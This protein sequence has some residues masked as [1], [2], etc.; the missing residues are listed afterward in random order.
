MKP[1]A[2]CGDW[3]LVLSKMAD[4]GLDTKIDVST[5]VTDFLDKSLGKGICSTEK[6]QSL[7]KDLKK[8]REQLHFQVC[9]P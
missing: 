4:A 5:K 3:F 2:V 6:I 8:K 1:C 9:T 7:L